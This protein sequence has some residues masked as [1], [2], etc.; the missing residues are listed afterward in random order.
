MR[1]SFCVQQAARC[2]IDLRSLR[3]RNGELLSGCAEG[4]AL[5]V[6]ANHVDALPGLRATP[7]PRGVQ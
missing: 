1:G 3:G 5:K 2:E 4:T 7:G 6:G